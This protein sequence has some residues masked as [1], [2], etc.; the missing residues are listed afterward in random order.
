[1]YIY[2]YIYAYVYLYTY[3][4]IYIYLY[5]HIY[6]NV[7]VYRYIHVFV[8]YIYISINQVSCAQTVHALARAIARGGPKLQRHSYDNW[9]NCTD[10]RL[11]NVGQLY[12]RKPIANVYYIIPG[13]D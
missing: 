3:I 10:M 1:M 7:Y 9:K 2:F 13:E 5:V 6:I 11:Q 12:N 8:L 4:H